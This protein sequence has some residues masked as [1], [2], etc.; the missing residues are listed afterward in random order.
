[1]ATAL[2][3]AAAAKGSPWG[4]KKGTEVV[5]SVSEMQTMVDKFNEVFGTT[6]T[7]DDIF[8]AEQ[9]RTAKERIENGQTLYEGTRNKKK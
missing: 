7:L 1:M 2:N 9:L 5:F 3:D 8:S 4:I 6:H